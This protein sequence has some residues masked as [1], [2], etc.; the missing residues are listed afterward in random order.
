MG[1]GD[2]AVPKIEPCASSVDFSFFGGNQTLTMEWSPQRRK[3]DKIVRCPYCVEDQT[4]KTMLRHSSGDWFVCGVCGHLAIPP[5]PFFQCTCT[6]CLAL[7]AMQENF[8]HK[9]SV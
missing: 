8:H 7:K 5:D 4:F 3:T 9:S 1:T 2:S 6:K